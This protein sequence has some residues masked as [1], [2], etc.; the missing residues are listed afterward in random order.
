VISYVYKGKTVQNILD[1]HLGYKN[2]IAFHGMKY[3]ILKTGAS[4]KYFMAVVFNRF[5]VG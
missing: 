5:I 3:I 1:L 2:A 4:A